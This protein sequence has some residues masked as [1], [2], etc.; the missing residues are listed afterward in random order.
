MGSQC[1]EEVRFMQ[2]FWARSVSLRL[3]ARMAEKSIELIG[4]FVDGVVSQL[5]LN[6]ADR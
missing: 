1:P 4:F 5:Q 3:R 2:P 6:R